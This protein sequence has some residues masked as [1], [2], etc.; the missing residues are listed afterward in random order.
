MIN[1]KEFVTSVPLLVM[2]ASTA[3]AEESDVA[4]EV[5]CTEVAFSRSVEN[6]DKDAFAAFIDE[7]ARFVGNTNAS[8]GRASIVEAWS[9]FFDEDGPRIVW[10]PQIVEVLEA[11]DLAI[12]RGP[13]RLRSLDENGK[14]VE[15]WGTFNSIWRRNSDGTWSVIFDAG[16]GSANSLEER[17]DEQI[18]VNAGKCD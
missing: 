2:M 13:Y 16:G 1:L 6:Q 18:E 10:R 5:R 11:G 12:S 8:R 3:L 14:P 15:E 9:A 4:K 17:L 7:D